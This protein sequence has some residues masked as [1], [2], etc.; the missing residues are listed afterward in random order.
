MSKN[1]TASYTTSNLGVHA[2][3]SMKAAQK[4]RE[5]KLDEDDE[6]EEVVE[7]ESRR[8]TRRLTRT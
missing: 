6:M 1:R 3:G 7:L 4:A 8:R 2:C 5:L